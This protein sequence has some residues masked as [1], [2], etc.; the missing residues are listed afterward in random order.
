[1]LLYRAGR[2]FDISECKLI[3]LCRGN[4]G[5][6]N[7][8]VL[9][10]AVAYGENLDRFSRYYG[11]SGLVGRPELKLFYTHI[12]VIRSAYESNVFYFLIYRNNFSVVAANYS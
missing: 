2:I 10:E 5:G 12:S 1:M 8:G 3:P 4:F 6:V 9:G 7:R 11:F